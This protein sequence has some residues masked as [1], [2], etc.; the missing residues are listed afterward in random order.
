MLYRRH[1]TQRMDP[2]RPVGLDPWSPLFPDDSAIFDMVQQLPR[3]SHMYT[4]S[5]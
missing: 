1:A 4:R 2:C 3:K 5:S